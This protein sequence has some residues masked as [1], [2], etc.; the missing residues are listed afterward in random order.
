[1]AD[2]TNT[3]P[4]AAAPGPANGAPSTSGQQIDWNSA[5]NPFKDYEARYK[6]V[7]PKYQKALSD[8]DGATLKI[9]ELQES[10]KKTT[11]DRE[12]L[13]L[14]VKDWQGKHDKALADLTALQAKHERM[15]VVVTQF[16]DL[17]PFLGSTPDTDLLP[18][19]SGEELTKKLAAFKEALSKK[20]AD[21]VRDALGGGTP[22]APPEKKEGDL[23]AQQLLSSAIQAQA[24]GK[25]DEYEKLY[26]QYIQKL[27]TKP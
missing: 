1:M 17:M 10:L 22:P 8:L 19:G 7:Q 15:Q 6:G 21:S 24:D 18:I 4:D 14:A 16:P 23:S 20:G 12:T 13:D 9:S 3:N 5:D 27:S 26:G 25:Q 11:G 2:N